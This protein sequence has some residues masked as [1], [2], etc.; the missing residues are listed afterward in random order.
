MFGQQPSR[1]E[2][3]VTTHGFNERESISLKFYRPK[4]CAFGKDGYNSSHIIPAFVLSIR[5]QP[6]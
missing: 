5:A 4:D 2:L 1:L 6:I 3:A